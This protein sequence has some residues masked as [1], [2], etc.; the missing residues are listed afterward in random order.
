MTKQQAIKKF[1]E[2]LP[3]LKEAMIKDCEKLLDCGGVNL[4]DYED[5]YLLPKILMTAIL[6]R[7]IWQYRP[8]TKEAKEVSK[9][10]LHF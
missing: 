9:N 7:Q 10:L 1:K 3:E 2:M 5:N 8:H 4:P 6:E